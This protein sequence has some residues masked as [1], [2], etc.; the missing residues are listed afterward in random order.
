MRE[1]VDFPLADIGRGFDVALR[2]FLYMVHPFLFDAHA[3]ESGE[4]SVGNGCNY[5][6]HKARLAGETK[7][8]SKNKRSD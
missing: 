4:N 3:L 8:E 2:C 1:E 7:L 5:G 6:N